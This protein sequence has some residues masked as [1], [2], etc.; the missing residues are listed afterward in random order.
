[1]AVWGV[2]ILQNLIFSQFRPR[3]I[4]YS[5]F[6]QSILDDK[7]L[8]IAVGQDTITGKMKDENGEEIIFR[9]VRVDPDLSQQ[10]AEHGVKFS[11]QVENT[12][13]RTLL[14]WLVPILLFF[15][16]WMFLM[17]RMQMGQAG[18]TGMNPQFKKKQRSKRLTKKQRDKKKK[19][20]GKGKKRR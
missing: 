2:L 11:G 1:M 7:V 14:S 5:E 6:I 9:T 8:E 18:M 4:A 13:F 17:R 20:K 19:G 15:G 3:V 16:I 10:L 12:F